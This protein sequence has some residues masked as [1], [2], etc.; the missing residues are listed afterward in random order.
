MGTSAKLNCTV[1]VTA[2]RVNIPFDA[3][4]IRDN[5]VINSSTPRHTLLKTTDENGTQIVTGLRVDNTTLNDN[6]AVY[7]C[8]ANVTTNSSVIL[9]VTGGKVHV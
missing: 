3:E 4:W 7:T 9:N 8:I 6:G 5:D 2:G 1:Q